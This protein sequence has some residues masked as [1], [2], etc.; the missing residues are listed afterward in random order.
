MVYVICELVI[1]RSH[2]TPFE[3]SEDDPNFDAGWMVNRQ[4]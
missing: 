1:S 2:S 4:A 3:K